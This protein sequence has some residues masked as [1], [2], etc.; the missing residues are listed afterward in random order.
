MGVFV[1]TEIWSIAQKE[2][3]REKFSSEKE[4][5]EFFR[6][7]SKAKS[8]LE[9]ILRTEIIYMTYHQVAEIC[10]VLGFRGTKLPLDH[11]GEFVGAI[12]KS[13]RIIKVPVNHEHMIVAIELSKE[14]GIHIWDFLCVVP[15]MDY[16][17]VFYTADLHFKHKIFERLKLKVENP[18]G[19]WLKT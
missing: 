19:R 16:V 11:V 6:L 10:H 7:H 17:E 1:D 3:I 15:I 13:E 5:K 12:L 8:F 4:F 9:E 14:S 2:P 18:L